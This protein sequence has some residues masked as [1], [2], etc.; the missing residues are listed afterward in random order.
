MKGSGRWSSLWVSRTPRN[1]ILGTCSK[2]PAPN[3]RYLSQRQD[4][5]NQDKLTIAP[6]SSSATSSSLDDPTSTTTAGIQDKL[7]KAPFH[8]VETN[9]LPPLFPWRHSPHPLARLDPTSLEFQEKGQLLGGNV[10]TSHPLIDEIATAWMFMNVPWYQILFFRQWQAD[11]AE[12]M[13]WA[14][15][16]GVAGILSNVYRGRYFL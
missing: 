12:N 7:L 6:S 11:L 9:H 10:Y 15:T 13:S 3:Y 14:F 5:P 2:H 8:R 16:Q 1:R 4:L